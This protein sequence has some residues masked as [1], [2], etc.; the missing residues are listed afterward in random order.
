M[1]DAVVTAGG[2]LVDSDAPGTLRAR[3]DVGSL[4]ELLRVRDELRAAGI[5]AT[6]IA[7]L[8]PGDLGDGSDNNPA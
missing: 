5:D 3:F 7:V 4:E 1:R 6:T 8:D 2:Q